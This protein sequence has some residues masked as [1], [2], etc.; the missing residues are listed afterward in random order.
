[1]GNK[2]LG[3]PQVKM[4]MHLMLGK[5]GVGIEIQPKT[6]SMQKRFE[7]F[8]STVWKEN[9]LFLLFSVTFTQSEHRKNVLEA[10]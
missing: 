6:V 3:Q 4:S 2:I 1:M 10:S 8:T 7:F 5:T 9:V